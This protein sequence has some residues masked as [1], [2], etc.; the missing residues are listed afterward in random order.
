MP[1]VC[2]GDAATGQ[3]QVHCA[4]HMQSEH[5]LR[6]CKTVSKW[7]HRCSDAFLQG[8]TNNSEASLQGSNHLPMNKFCLVAFLGW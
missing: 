4:K 6:R 2:G 5:V 7:M 8:L 1:C 3:H